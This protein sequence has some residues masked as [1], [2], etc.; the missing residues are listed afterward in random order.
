MRRAWIVSLLLVFVA[1][2]PHDTR[3]DPQKFADFRHQ[4]AA[5]DH[6]VSA[7]SDAYTKASRAALDRN[8]RAAFDRAALSLRDS[9]AAIRTDAAAI[10]APHFGNSDARNQAQQVLGQLLAGIDANADA[11][12]AD[13]A[14]RDPHHP[15][16]DE[17]AAV[18]DARNR[19][20]DAAV[21]ESN[22][23]FSLSADLGVTPD[24]R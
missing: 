8:D 5:I 22:A 11:A 12:K 24:A 23:L 13:Q 9:M 7:D 14:M 16:A 21:G 20:S 18:L 2:G 6:R 3:T 19:V 10:R 4:I 17:L 1:C 15:T